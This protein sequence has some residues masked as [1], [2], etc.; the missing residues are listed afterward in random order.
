M[1]SKFILSIYNFILWFSDIDLSYSKLNE[2]ITNPAKNSLP[3]IRHTIYEQ[4]LEWGQFGY[5]DD[6]GFWINHV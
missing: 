2:N 4:E 6:Q 1:L 5:F 3:I